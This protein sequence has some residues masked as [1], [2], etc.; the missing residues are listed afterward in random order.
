MKKASWIV[1]IF[2]AL[3]CR[4]YGAEIPHPLIT[5]GYQEAVFSVSDIEAHTAFYQNIA[6]WTILH[7][8]EIHPNLLRGYGL[9]D[10][11]TGEQVV[12]GNPGTKRGY[13]RLVQFDGAHQ[14]Q[15]R[16]SAQ[17]WDTGGIFDVNSRVLD[18]R[19]TF[20]QFQRHG[21]QAAADPVEFSFGPFIVNEWLTR[22]PDGI[23]F[24]LMERIAP[25]LKGWPHLRKLSRLFNATQVVADIESAR[26]FYQDALGF[27]TY[28]VYVV[29]TF[30]TLGGLI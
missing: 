20:V 27:K 29:R 16:S 17:P 30:R 5:G 7:Q 21:W 11:I 23:V 12:L 3:S 18:M 22:G 28:M 25:P 9:A 14:V 10:G 24:A 15:I 13:I 19:T 4:A 8:G 2:L 1:L 26:A 6:G